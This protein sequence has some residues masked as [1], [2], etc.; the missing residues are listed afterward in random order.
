[1]P[2]QVTAAAPPFEA[3]AYLAAEDAVKQIALGQ[4]AGRWLCLF[5][6][7]TD[8]GRI[9]PTEVAAFATVHEQFQ[10]RGCEVLGCSCDTVAV[11]RAWCTH[12]EALR[13]L[14]FALLADVTKRIAMDYGVLLPQEGIPLR[15]TFLIDPDGVLRWMSVHDTRTGRGIEELLRSLD[16]LQTG[17]PCP[18]D[19]QPGQATL[20]QNEG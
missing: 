6:Y 7:S 10:K 2:V 4:Y 3:R 15:G 11:H 13:G 9:C 12:V 19:W 17:R 14:P 18:C 20:D 8:F 16:A 1:M 5:F